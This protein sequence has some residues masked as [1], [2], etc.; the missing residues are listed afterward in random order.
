MPS[1]LPA[2][3]SARR[4]LR[5]LDRYR[6]RLAGRQSHR[7]RGAQRDRPHRGIRQ[8]QPE[9]EDEAASIIAQAV[10]GEAARGGLSAAVV[11]AQTLAGLVIEEALLKLGGINL[12]ARPTTPT[13][14]PAPVPPRHERGCPVNDVSG[15]TTRDTITGKLII[16]SA[17]CIARFNQ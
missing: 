8:E 7:R 11:D 10:V 9:E 3:I 15:A 13:I 4:H 2:K 1:R 17:E 12:S 5:P 16:C 6:A 14:V